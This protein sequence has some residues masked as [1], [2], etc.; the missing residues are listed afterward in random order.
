M[1]HIPPEVLIVRGYITGTLLV[2]FMG[3]LQWKWLDI[4]FDSKPCVARGVWALPDMVKSGHGV[5]CIH[6]IG[7]SGD[8]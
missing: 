4:D 7:M 6:R 8:C 1:A 2:V 5:P 3:S